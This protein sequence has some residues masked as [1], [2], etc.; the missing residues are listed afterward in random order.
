M[1]GTNAAEKPMLTVALDLPSAQILADQ[2]STIQDLQ[3]VMECCKRLLTELVKPEEEREEVVPQAIW[4]AALISY[5]RCFAKGKRFGL[6]TED[7][8]SLPLQGQVMKF[9]NWVVGER[10][11]LATHPAN[12]FEMA[13]VATA[14]SPPDQPGRR[15][16][17]ITVLSASHVLVD[18]T[19]VRQLGALASE[20]AKQTAEKAQKQQDSVLAE[21]QKLDIDGLY[22][23]P[24]VRTQPAESGTADDTQQAELSGRSCHPARACPARAC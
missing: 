15:V 12:P 7:V 13:T 22:K 19:G 11:K 1:A 5:D 16:E 21:A 10:N 4:S 3:F 18:G 20:L 14:L 8:R 2:I 6:T 17:G 9:H 24:P 23:L